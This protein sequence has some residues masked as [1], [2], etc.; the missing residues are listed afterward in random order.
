MLALLDA[1]EELAREPALPDPG[2]AVDREEVR[3]LVRGSRGRA[4]SR[5]ARARSRGRR[6]ARRPTARG[7]RCR[8]SRPGARRAAARRSPSARSGRPPRSRRRRSSAAGQRARS[9]SRPGSAACWSRAA[10][11][12]A[13]PVAN[14][15]SDSSATTS[16]ASTPIRASSPSSCTES[17][18]AAAAR[19][20][21]SASSSCACRDP[22][23]RHDRVAG[24]LL[25]DA[26]VRGDAVRD[27]LEERV[28]APADDLG[29]ACGDELGRADEIDEDD[30]CELAF[31][32]VIVVT[33][34]RVTAVASPVPAGALA[35]ARARSPA[36]SRPTTSAVSTR[37]S[38]TR[39][40]RTRSAAPTSSTSSRSG[41][42]S[43]AT[44]GSPPRRCPRR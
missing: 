30:G 24:E 16:P 9:G 38:S 18:I 15:E 44:C 22:E 40:A 32:S 25:D 1:L 8:G 13:S 4:C 7:R 10:T 37:T 29:V 17:R 27:V 39:K 3:A 31:H 21:R 23:S 14:V 12:T 11:L 34:S 33:R 35:S 42:R 5:A 6:T 36:S 28:D 43:A 26:A 2:L 19:T 41:S 20:A